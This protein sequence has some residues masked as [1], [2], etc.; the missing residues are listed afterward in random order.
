MQN[1]LRITTNVQSGGKIEII[2][3]QLPVGATVEI[4][5][6]LAPTQA[7]I[8]HSV[9]DVLKSALGGLMFKN[10]HDVDEHLRVEHDAWNALN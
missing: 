3:A 4:Y 1:A 8:K 2:D 7:N 6:Q 10:A 9:L 5:V